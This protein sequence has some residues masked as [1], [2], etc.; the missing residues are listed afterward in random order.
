MSL[1]HL[2]VRS[3]AQWLQYP[4][5]TIQDKQQMGEQK[6][7]EGAEFSPNHS[8]VP[9]MFVL[10]AQRQKLPFPKTKHPN[11]QLLG[12]RTQRFLSSWI[13]GCYLN[14]FPKNACGW[15]WLKSD[16][17]KKA[18]Y[19]WWWWF[20]WRNIF[21]LIIWKTGSLLFCDI[22]REN[23]QGFQCLLQIS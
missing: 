5:T 14:A 13:H 9:E 19:C 11:S 22:L 17:R 10:Q 7:L 16:Q 8:W 3:E 20:L 1:L 15:S 2:T 6:M 23:F 18:K 4:Y 21:S 12:V